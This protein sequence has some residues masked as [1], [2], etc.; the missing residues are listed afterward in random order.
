MILALE[1]VSFGYG[2]EPDLLAN[3]NLRIAKGEF[4]A[5]LGPSGSGKSTLLNLVAGLLEP[6]SGHIRFNRQQLQG[7]NRDVGYMTQGDTL[8]PWLTVAKNVLLPLELRGIP[9]SE[10][11]QRLARAL[12]LVGLTDALH[13]HPSEL[14]GGMRRR[15]LLA[16]SLIY[17]PPMLLMD[18]PFAALD[19]QLRETMHQEL[20]ST[21][22]RLDESVMFVTHDIAESVLLADRVVVLSHRPLCILEDVAIP[23]GKD[24][25]LDELRPSPEYRLLEA[26]VR[27]VLRQGTKARG[28]IGA[29]TPRA[30]IQ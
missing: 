29:D 20:L 16:R 27:E 8:L 22:N 4:V 18:E 6:R 13:K 10:R 21:V 17:G 23:F 1:D 2:D 30:S 28:P 25:N 14:S 7:I 5:F 11:Q 26:H 19:A 15:A 24:R 3:F 9:R 12:D